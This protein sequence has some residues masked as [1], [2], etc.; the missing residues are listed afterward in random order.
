MKSYIHILD[1]DLLLLDIHEFLTI[2]PPSQYRGVEFKPLRLLKTI[3]NQLVNLRGQEI[4][5]HLTLI[6][7]HTNPTLCSYLDL[8]FKHQL[9]SLH[10]GHSAHES[11]AHHQGNGGAG[12][13]E[14]S[15]CAQMQPAHVR[16]A[17]VKGAGTATRR[18]SASGGGGG[19][20]TA[21]TELLITKFQALK[22]Q[23]E[24]EALKSPRSHLVS[25]RLGRERHDQSA[26]KDQ[27]R[28]LQSVPS[29]RHEIASDD[30]SLHTQ[31][32]D[33]IPHTHTPPSL[34]SRAHMIA[35]GILH[36]LRRSAPSPRHHPTAGVVH[37]GVSETLEVTAGAIADSISSKQGRKENEE[38]R[39][40][41]ADNLHA[42][43]SSV[44]SL[45]ERL[46]RLKTE[47]LLHP[48]P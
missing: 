23:V 28:R 17:E 39:T 46:A 45:Q 12:T 9:Q 22:S 38:T 27:A 36:D 2:H 32:P 40:E 16:T 14:A 42:N 30:A 5:D 33:A 35:S 4:R 25:P 15:A 20:S 43:N 21:A 48:T 44:L 13:K 18:G 1:I 41:H 34:H 47:R 10:Q 6:P 7:V 37:N 26:D 19:S 24:Q 11:I 8:V 3:I 31:P 29:E